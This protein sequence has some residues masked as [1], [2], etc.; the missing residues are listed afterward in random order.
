MYFC[1][2]KVVKRFSVTCGA[3]ASHSGGGDPPVYS[4][5]GFGYKGMFNAGLNVQF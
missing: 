1:P 4:G 2:S 5:A 3:G